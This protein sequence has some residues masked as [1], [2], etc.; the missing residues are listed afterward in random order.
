MKKQTQYLFHC[1][2]AMN[3]FLQNT[4][5]EQLHELINKLK[6]AE[7]HAKGATN[8]YSK[9]LWFRFGKG[10][11]LCHTIADLSNGLRDK[12]RDFYIE[13]MLRV[14]EDTNP[15]NELRVFFS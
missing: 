4:G 6:E 15:D 14:T 10:D 2:N 7:V 13:S 11:N 8:N 3:T 1:T 12:N 5:P 9:S